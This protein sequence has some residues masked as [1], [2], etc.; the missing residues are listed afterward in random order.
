MTRHSS[1]VGIVD[2]TGGNDVSSFLLGA[3]CSSGGQH[4]KVRIKDRHIPGESMTLA[5]RSSPRPLLRRMRV[6]DA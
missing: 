1:L 5:T 4:C 2:T 3:V 6:V